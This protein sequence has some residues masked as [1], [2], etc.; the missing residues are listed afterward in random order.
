MN[1]VFE[2][3]F[4][5]TIILIVVSTLIIAFIKKV[6]IDKSLKGFR[7]DYVHTVMHDKT[8]ISGKLDVKNTGIELLFRENEAIGE[9][10]EMRLYHI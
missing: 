1:A 9:N 3:T 4:L 10:G 6:H 8:V 7:D 5:L 2:D